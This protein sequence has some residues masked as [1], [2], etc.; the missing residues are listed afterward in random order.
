MRELTESAI[1]IL[2]R[3]VSFN[4]VSNR[5]NRELID[6]IKDYLSELGVESTI[7]PDATGQKA[8]LFATIGDPTVPGVVLS[9]HTDV[10]PVEGQVWQREPFA[11]TRENG[12][13]Y[14][15]GTSDMKGFVAC[16]MAIVPQLKAAEL[17]M[18]VHLAFSYDEEV[19]CL[20]V[21][22]LIE[23]M[24]NSVA[25]PVAAL[26]GEPSNMTVVD[27]HKGSRGILTTITGKAVH[28]SRVDLGTSAVLG[29]M[30]IVQQMETCSDELEAQSDPS[31]RFE[32]PYSTINVGVIRGG[33]ARNLVPGDCVLQWE[34]RGTRPDITDSTQARITKFI[35]QSVLPDMQQRFEGSRIETSI[36]YDVPPLV[37]I[38]GSEAETLAKRFAGTNETFAVNYGTEAGFFAMADVPAV[39]CGPGSDTEAHIADEWIAIEQIDKCMTFLEALVAH[40]QA[41]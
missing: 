19:G 7:I 2:D 11:V 31:L 37:A 33:T 9:G 20:G 30:K 22:S 1:T 21:H 27:S 12:R 39:I 38:P 3:L 16:A 34:I 8:N 32:L 28:S 35:D 5:S 17:K 15:R 24:T 36:V 14:G 40:V 13:L 26:I 29:A 41:A 23:H 4:T 18:P 6:Y 10:V 25:A